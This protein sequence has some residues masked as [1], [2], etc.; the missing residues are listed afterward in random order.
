MPMAVERVLWTGPYGSGARDHAVASASLDPSALWVV[1]SPMARDQVRA[2]LAARCRA[3]GTGQATG[4]IPRVWCWADLWARVRAGSSEGPAVL[5]DGAAG[6]VFSEAIRRA[7]QAGE[8]EA[9]EAVLDW[10][11]YRRRLRRRFAAWTGDERPPRDTAPADP[12]AAAEWAA[13]RRYRALL[14][15]LGA[16]DEPGL[17]VWASR[18]LGRRSAGEA[19][20][21]AQA[22]FLDFE[23]PT[24]AMWRVL[25]HAIRRARSVRVTLGFEASDGEL[26]GSPYEANADVRDRLVRTL[27]FAE[28][29]LELDLWRPAGL[30]DLERVLF[31]P[32]AVGGS[33][34]SVHQ[35][36]A[37]RGAPLGDGVARVLAREIGDRL[38]AGI[39]PD[40]IL[41]V[42]RKWGEQAD[43]ALEALRDWGI[44]AVAEPRRPLGSD[45]GVAALLL[46][47]GLP[48]DEWST[49]RVIRLL[50]NGRIQPGGPG[51]DLLSMA[52]AAA[53]VRTSPVFRGRE[54][55]LNWLDRAVANARDNTVKAERARL[56]R[57]VVERVLG[58]IEPIDRPR[59]FGDQVDRLFGLARVLG[60]VEAAAGRDSAGL[61]R[62][63]DALEDRAA[64]IERLGRDG[65]S[66]SWADFAEEV[67]S[68]AGELT[69]PPIDAR[70]GS[71][72]LASVDEVEGARAAHVILADLAEGTF[73][74]REAV[75]AFLSLRP[76]A[77][78]NADA[79][80][81][82][83]RE[84]LRFLRMLGS[85]G[86]SLT[87]VYPTTDAKGQD[88]LRAG[89][90]DELMGHLDPSALAACH[91][92]VRRL[93][94]A[95]VD[96]PELA[97][98]PADQRVR[99]VAIARTRGDSQELA[100]LL[101]RPGHRRP[102]A[103]TAAALRV[104]SR[105]LRGTPF[106]EY[107]GLL[108]DGHVMLDVAALFPPEYL[109]SASQLETYSDCP[110]LFY[111]KYVL[112]LEPAERRDE[113]DEDY[114][115]RGS[116]IHRILEELEQLKR[117]A[118]DAEDL[119]PLEQAALEHALAAEPVDPSEVA[120]G[121]A[122]IE[123][124]RLVQTVL[125]YRVQHIRYAT[126]GPAQPVPHQFEVSFGDEDS[127]HPW[128]ELGRGSR[129]VRLQGKID[130]ID[131]VNS[132]DGRAFRV[133]DYKSGHGPS[134]TEVRNAR[135]LQLP[136]Y[137]MAVERLDLTEQGL[138][139]G[140]VGYWALREK[141]YTAIAFEA[142]DTVQAQLESYV[143][144]LVDR[145]RRG[146]FVV[147]SQLDGCEGFCEYRAICRVRQARLAAKRYDRPEAPQWETVRRGG[148]ST[149]GRGG[150]SA[151]GPGGAP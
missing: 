136:L 87:L 44:P 133:I 66:R 101:D 36:L 18:R 88:L 26:A 129:A 124:R 107:D 12:V 41:V 68:L 139:L 39:P 79:R 90:L 84:M 19:S 121:L 95:L 70:P 108:R 67:E 55:L 81:A 111:C 93:D 115:E 147:D 20:A 75:E 99:A 61:D 11:G 112:K 82:F 140:D 52:A 72:R 25:D 113:I 145:L 7:R 35:G 22:T 6:A 40:D 144:S 132:P 138:A 2:E 137:A 71:V 65:G 80:R 5:S 23:S 1:P 106:G 128:L 141:G 27:G 60:I 16:E 37:I 14:A 148:K 32:G 85:S 43:I 151:G 53:V 131:I 42:F 105:R 17:A 143:G 73:P 117:N 64:V 48:G 76:G 142:W 54:T 97:G 98:S 103:G 57:T 78:A 63:R 120:Q 74:G 114:T 30:R 119:E 59:K 24:R 123:R 134:A 86:T 89:F 9:V 69:V 21:I 83:S 104:L 91:R 8:T 149:G 15:E 33:R 146:E 130:R 50:R 49:D 100:G 135:K 10:P 109:F 110:F 28:S 47:I 29:T 118:A 62:L 34:V 46:A 4:Q 38:D 92:A 3:I 56:A 102:L 31:R 125:R 126:D 77:S 51:M 96:A 116:R 58:L 122:E 94:P 150:P 127:G 45:P 13:F